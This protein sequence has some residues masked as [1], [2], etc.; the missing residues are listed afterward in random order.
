MNLN[1][2]HQSPVSYLHKAVLLSLTLLSFDPLF[3]TACE[4]YETPRASK[5]LPSIRKKSS[6][7]FALGR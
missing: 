6:F 2:S 3:P 5:Y 4:P 7:I 1:N